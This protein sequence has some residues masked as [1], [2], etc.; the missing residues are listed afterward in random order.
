MKWF[1]AFIDEVFVQY[2]LVLVCSQ[3]KTTKNKKMKLTKIK[4]IYTT[5]QI[6]K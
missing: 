4:G 1:L 6:K 2:I 3:I 5:K